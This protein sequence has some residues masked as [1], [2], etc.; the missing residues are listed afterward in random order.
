MPIAP[1][2]IE[3][4]INPDFK[5]AKQY[6]FKALLQ[7]HKAYAIML[8]E[9]SILE[10]SLGARIIDALDYID[11]NEAEDLELKNDA[12]DLFFV[13]EK[14]LVEL[15]GEASNHRTG[16]QAWVVGDICLSVEFDWRS[17]RR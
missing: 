1:E 14:K 3:Y 4:I 7:L 12:E 9:S 5:K 17:R 10:K 6:D 2:I 16:C 8:V 15:A 13:V 11:K